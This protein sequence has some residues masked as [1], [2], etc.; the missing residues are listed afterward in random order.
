MSRFRL[1]RFMLSRMLAALGDQFMMFA[2]PLYILKVTGSVKWSGLA[3]AIEWLPRLFFLP[4]SGSLADRINVRNLYRFSDLG[5][6]ILI[7]GSYLAIHVFP[8]SSFWLLSGMMACMS[9]LN[10]LAFIGMEA[11]L[12]RQLPAEDMPKAQSWLQG[13]DQLSQVLGPALAGAAAA[14]FEL[15]SVIASGAVFFGVSFLNSL[16]LP[17]ADFTPPAPKSFQ[18]IVVESYT[19]G[20]TILFQKKMLLQLCALTWLVNLIYG[21]I[22]VVAPAIVTQ[23]LM[24]PEHAFGLMQTAAGI[25]CIM[26]F[27]AAPELVRRIGLHGVGLMAFA[28]MVLG[29]WIGSL[30]G[31]ILVFGLGLSTLFAFDGMFN[32]YIRSLRARI[33]PKEDFG[34]V[35]GVII[36]VNNFSLPISGFVV[37]LT[38]GVMTPQENLLLMSVIAAT[39]GVLT[40]LTG[41]WIFGYRTVMPSLES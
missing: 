27:M 25:A 15:R 4:V 37:S 18:A 12:P 2:V 21:T 14:F 19:R 30:A 39:L 17:K 13:V 33:I 6:M 24:Q 5:R 40:I 16:S 38:A 11:T 32:V 26:A 28:G 34:K 31:N 35:T 9:I 20:F 3:F 36:L 10:S 8:S 7:L 22:L 1:H 29:A 23:R 41:K